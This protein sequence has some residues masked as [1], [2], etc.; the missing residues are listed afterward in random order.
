VLRFP[1]LETMKLLRGKHREH[2]EDT[3]IGDNFL[4]ISKTQKI[5]RLTHEIASN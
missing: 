1:L 5:T 4:R 2:T 3:G